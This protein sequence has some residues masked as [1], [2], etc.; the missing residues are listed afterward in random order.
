[1]SMTKMKTAGGSMHEAVEAEVVRSHMGSFLS[2]SPDSARHWKRR[3][4]APSTIEMKI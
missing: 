1:M 3:E 4:T 2:P